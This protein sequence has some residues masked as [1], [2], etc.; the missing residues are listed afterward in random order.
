MQKYAPL[1]SRD[2][3][4]MGSIHEQHGINFKPLFTGHVCKKSFNY[5]GATFEV[6]NNLFGG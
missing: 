2:F 1:M 5:T 3:E 6:N 4:T